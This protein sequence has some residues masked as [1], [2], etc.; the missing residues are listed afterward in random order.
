MY[1]FINVLAILFLSQTVFSANYFPERVL[2]SVESTN[3]NCT[4]SIRING[5]DIEIPCEPEHHE[6]TPAPTDVAPA[7]TD[8]APAP[9]DVTPAPT[10][11]APTPTDETPAPT[12]VTPAS[13]DTSGDLPPSLY[14]NDNDDNNDDA[15]L[16]FLRGSNRFFF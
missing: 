3:Q 11:V 4:V 6:E 14:E 10:D 13:T 5:I 1:K 15:P 9:T 12:D 7:P 16:P 8:V 2:Q